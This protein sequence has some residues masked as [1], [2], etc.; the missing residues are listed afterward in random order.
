MIAILNMYFIKTEKEQA[1]NLHQKYFYSY[2]TYTSSKPKGTSNKFV[3]ETLKPKKFLK[4]KGTRNEST[5]ENYF[6]HFCNT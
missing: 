4:T 2:D 1:I 5:P 6:F 3:P